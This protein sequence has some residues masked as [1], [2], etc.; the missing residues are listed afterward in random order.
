MTS[1]ADG[2]D[3]AH[4]APT[5]DPAAAADV[6]TFGEALTVFLAEPGV[7]LSASH[8]LPAFRGRR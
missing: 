6:V 7:P 3:A 5:C 4:L 2:R 8:D 1:T